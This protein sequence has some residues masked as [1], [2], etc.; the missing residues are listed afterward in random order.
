MTYPTAYRSEAARSKGG[1][2]LSKGPPAP[3]PTSLG[4]L[5]RR[6]P[7]GTPLLDAAI[8]ERQRRD[9]SRGKSALHS[10]RRGGG[11]PSPQRSRSLASRLGRFARGPHLASILDDVAG[12][13]R[14][15][16]AQQRP[17]YRAIHPMPGFRLVQSNCCAGQI[18]PPDRRAQW[19]A[20]WDCF[21]VNQ[22]IP[23]DIGLTSPYTQGEVDNGTAWWG[24][25]T[26]FPT[27]YRTDTTWAPDGAVAG[28][29]PASKWVEMEGLNA[30]PSI[31]AGELPILAPAPKVK[32]LPSSLK[33]RAG[34][35]ADEYHPNWDLG[36]WR[37]G[38]E[39]AGQ[40]AGEQARSPVP[41]VSMAVWPKWQTVPWQHFAKPPG[42]GTKERKARARSI[43]LT[44]TSFPG[45]A[46]D[47]LDGIY[48]ALPKKV[49]VEAWRK[50]RNKPP[51]PTR[52]A[53]L[54]YE[55]LK[56][57][58]LERAL[59]EVAFE[60]LVTDRVYGSIGKHSKNPFTKNQDG[61][62]RQLAAS[63]AGEE[64]S[65]HAPAL[66]KLKDWLWG[67]YTAHTRDAGSLYGVNYSPV[68]P[69][70]G[71]SL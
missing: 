19:P 65:H 52:K 7:G 5:V 60:Q 16:L 24:E 46:L 54:I 41:R 21:C 51:R 58:D 40:L 70:F 62:G 25:R 30:H 31:N 17:D 14:L 68:Y 2:G 20:P 36:Q 49:Q 23:G 39:A 18:F 53:E 3:P 61:G 55:H 45:E 38:F 15:A 27:R 37:P 69:R 33:K 1:R 22:A 56:D 63:R 64:I 12:A 44:L 57:L 67:Q 59:F 13:L 4:D 66:S 47:V 35:E 48:A 32:P 11:H 42:T 71:G 6:S 50:A 26:T 28:E 9:A 34:N 8:R 29:S 10:R 43:I